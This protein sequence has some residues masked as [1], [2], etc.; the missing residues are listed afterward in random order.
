MFALK[1]RFI[2]TATKASELAVVFS[3]PIGSFPF[4]YLGMAMS[5]YKSRVRDYLPLINK[6]KRRVSMTNTWLSM[7]V[8]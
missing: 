3:C 8:G 1:D 7:Q 4:T 5:I 6:I 2:A